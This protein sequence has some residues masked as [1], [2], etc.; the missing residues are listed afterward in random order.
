M[1]NSFGTRDELVDLLKSLYKRDPKNLAKYNDYQQCVS[2]RLADESL[3]PQKIANEM[4][5]VSPHEAMTL[6]QE[7]K[8]NEEIPFRYAEDGCY[9][10]TYQMHRITEKKGINMGSIYI[11]GDFDVKTPKSISAKAHWQYHVAPVIPVY[12]DRGNEMMVIDP[13]L[14]D[15]PVPVKVWRDE[16][17]DEDS[18]QP[19]CLFY[20][21][22]FSVEPDDLPTGEPSYRNKKNTQDELARIAKILKEYDEKNADIEDDDDEPWVEGVSLHQVSRDDRMEMEIGEHDGVYFIDRD[23]PLFLD[24]LK[25]LKKE[26]NRPLSFQVDPVTLEIRSIAK[27]KPVRNSSSR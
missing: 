3:P 17:V 11:E 14:F 10:R 21:N 24:M 23:N 2:G 8:D 15:A 5:P 4:T 1:P 27:L 16:I 22:R 13:S 25:L 6:F 19:Y 9:A 18:E 12:T 20:S 7:F 26:K